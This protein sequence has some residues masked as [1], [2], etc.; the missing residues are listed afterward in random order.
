MV[1]LSDAIL[2]PDIIVGAVSSYLQKKGSEPRL[3]LLEPSVKR[4]FGK[5]IPVFLALL[6]VNVAVYDLPL[7]L[8][9]LKFPPNVPTSPIA[10][11][12]IFS[13]AEN[14]MVQ[15]FNNNTYIGY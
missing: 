1:L 5:K 13:F 2:V 9:E 15:D 4:F 3:L 12:V 6:G 8:K 10:N 7:P 11:P 14:T